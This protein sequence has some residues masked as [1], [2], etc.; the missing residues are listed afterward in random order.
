MNTKKLTRSLKVDER[1]G[2]QHMAVFNPMHE[3][4]QIKNFGMTGT[5]TDVTRNILRHMRVTLKHDFFYLTLFDGVRIDEG[6]QVIWEKSFSFYNPD[7]FDNIPV[8]LYK[9]VRQH[10]FS[11]DLEAHKIYSSSHEVET[12]EFLHHAEENIISLF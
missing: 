9:F 5:S 3:I 8:D 4:Q 7:A 11:S 1:D 12:R 10:I 2:E 6:R